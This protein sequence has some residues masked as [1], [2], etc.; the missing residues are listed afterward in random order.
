DRD[1]RAVPL[2]RHAAHGAAA[3]GRRVLAVAPGWRGGG[4]RRRVR[5]PPPGSEAAAAEVQLGDRGGAGRA[6][7]PGRRRG[8]RPVRTWLAA[9][10]A[11]AVAAA[12]GGARG[13]AAVPAAP[14]RLS[15]P[16]RRLVGAA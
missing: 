4:R 8:T 6:R 7:G 1:D 14:G 16:G 5:V 12:A 13:G 10:G 9:R 15:R 2:R 11:G 3:R